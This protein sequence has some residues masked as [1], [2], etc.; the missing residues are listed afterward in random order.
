MSYIRV[1]IVG[2]R[3]MQ[4]LLGAYSKWFIVTRC[5][6]DHND[7][8]PHLLSSPQVQSSSNTGRPIVDSTGRPRL[9]HQCSFHSITFY[10]HRPY[11]CLSVCHAGGSVKDGWS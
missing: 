5:L 4:L 8:K 1:Y 3:A 10:S 7:H 6:S 2:P 11:V 9:R